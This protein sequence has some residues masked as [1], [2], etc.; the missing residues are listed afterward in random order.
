MIE[1]TTDTPEDLEIRV[2]SVQNLCVSLDLFCKRADYK[3]GEAYHSMLQI[4]ALDADIER[5]ARRNA[6]TSS[7]AA[8]FPFLS[9]EICDQSG[10]LLGI[11][12]RNCSACM[13]WA[14]LPD[15]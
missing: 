14:R 6:L 2:A 9:Y 1:V 15:L 5:K 4:L 7:V 13:P 3:H 10:I 11:N 8:A 12:C